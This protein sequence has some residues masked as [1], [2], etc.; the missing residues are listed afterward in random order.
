LSRLSRSKGFTL[1]ELLLALAIFSVV[2]LAVSATFGMGINTWKKLEGVTQRYQEARLL[3]DR[4]GWE[5]RNCVR[6]DIKSFNDADNPEGYDF[7]GEKDKLYFFTTKENG[8]SAVMYR[9]KAGEDSSERMPIF[10]LERTSLGF[11]TAPFKEEVK[12]EIILDLMK[13]VEFKYLKK[14]ENEMKWQESWTGEDAGSLPLQVWI[15]IVFYVPTAN[16]S[17]FQEV[18]LDKYVDI[19]SPNKI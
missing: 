18:R 8:I 13:E 7:Y 11:T 6:M 1:V 19:I 17:E 10:C 16:K 4:F 5:L 15:K 12:G 9:K 2:G 3:L 14:I